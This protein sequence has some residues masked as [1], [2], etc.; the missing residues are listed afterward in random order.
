MEEL[1]KSFTEFDKAIR[2]ERNDEKAT[3]SEKRERVLRRLSEGIKRQRE[4]GVTIP[5]YEPFNQG[6]YAMDTG[7][8]PLNGDYDIDVGLR[9]DLAKDDHTDPVQVKKWVYEAV[10]GHTKRVEVRRSCV[11]V[12]YQEGGEPSYH[13]DLAVYSRGKSNPDGHDHL[14]KGKLGSAPE[15][16]AWEMSDP[17]G[18]CEH[19]ANCQSGDDAEQFRRAI[20]A[21]KRWKDVRFSKDGAA[22]PRGIALT[23]AAYWWFRPVVKVVDPFANETVRDDRAALII[24][25]DAMLERFADTWSDDEKMSTPRLKVQ[26]PVQPKSDLCARMT[27]AQM[28][29]FKTRLEELRDAL[30]ATESEIDLHAA[31]KALAKHFGDDFPVPPKSET[32]EKTGRAITSSG[33]SA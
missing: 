22:A 17:T 30:R 33:N 18:L 4:E 5:S 13:V 15:H 12:F 6:S 26:L 32:A 27:N 7:V 24:L 16:R 10:D 2:L 9:F 23:V 8:K 21:L 3:L 14:A 28:R 11:T 25:I 29:D 20:R 19:I 31:C 1:Q